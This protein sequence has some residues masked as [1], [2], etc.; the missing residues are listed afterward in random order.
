MKPT[1]LLFVP[2]YNCENQIVRVLKQI[3]E[4]SN[5][6][7]FNEIILIDNCSKDNTVKAC[8]EFMK[9][10]NLSIKVN[11]LQNLENIGLGGSHKVAFNYAISHN[12]THIVVFHGDDQ[13]TLKNIGPYLNQ[14]DKNSKTLL[15]ARFCFKSNLKGYSTFRIFGNIFFNIL[16]SI[17]N[18]QLIK[19][20]GSGLNLFKVSD[21]KDKYFE[22]LPNDLTFNYFLLLH[23]IKSKIKYK[24]IPI[25]WSESDQ[26]SNVKLF[27]QTLKLFKILFLGSFNFKYLVKACSPRPINYSNFYKPLI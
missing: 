19:D 15:G 4:F 26:V 17:L 12:F 13:G 25:D 11:I 18:F 22:N 20:L 23:L 10:N 27:N 6:V 7:L 14:L 21:L 2:M 16:F 24:F 1:I 9:N 8:K 3:K 5:P